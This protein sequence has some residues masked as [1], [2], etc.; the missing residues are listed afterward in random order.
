MPL[1]PKELPIGGGDVMKTLD[2]KPSRAVGDVL[3]LL[4]EKVLEDPSLGERERLL[5]I[6]PEA[7]R[8]VTGA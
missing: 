7:Y 5:A 6:L 3:E 2:V 4:L 1:L 8:E